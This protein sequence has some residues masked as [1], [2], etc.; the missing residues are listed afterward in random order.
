LSPFI[1]RRTSLQVEEEEEQ[2]IVPY[3]LAQ[4]AKKQ[5]GPDMYAMTAGNSEGI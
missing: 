2:A 4:A 3:L 5:E 1:Q